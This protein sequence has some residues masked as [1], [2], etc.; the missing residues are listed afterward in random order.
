MGNSLVQRENFDTDASLKCSDML[1][2]LS[3]CRHK[4]QFIETQ[5]FLFI[6]NVS[7]SGNAY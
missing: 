3:F 4:L 6:K 1:N 5:I 2:A 7:A